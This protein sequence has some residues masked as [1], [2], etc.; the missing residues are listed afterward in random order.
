MQTLYVVVAS[1]SCLALGYATAAHFASSAKMALQ[2]K[3]S[4]ETSALKEAEKQIKALK[5]GNGA[6]SSGKSKD[7]GKSKGKGKGNKTEK[8]TKKLEKQAADAARELERLKDAQM[9][10][11]KAHTD[12]LG[13]TKA[14]LAEARANTETAVEEA[15]AEATK[16]AESAQAETASTDSTEDVPPEVIA[17]LG[18][19][20]ASLDAILATLVE[21]DGQQGALLGDA[22]GI[23][24]AKA[25]DKDT[26]ENT[27]AASNTIVTLPQKLDGI[28]PLDKHFTYQLEDGENAIAGRAFESEGELLA[29]TTVGKTAPN[30][31]TLVAVIESLSAALS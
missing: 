20:G 7:K 28:L 1:T 12:A 9:A 6:K 22:N 15:K 13:K 31:A 29:L 27:A 23:I 14:Q 18:S 25:G 11:D 30:Q 10:S 2:A 26:V 5:S 4:D 17:A 19:A 21:H 16:A 8:D 3:L 24:I